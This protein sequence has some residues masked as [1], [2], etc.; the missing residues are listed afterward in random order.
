[1][2]GSPG[3][4]QPFD[5]PAHCRSRNRRSRQRAEPGHLRRPDRASAGSCHPEPRADFYSRAHPRPQD[6][7][8][9]IEVADSSIGYDQ[10]VK[11]LAYAMAGIPALV[12]ID[13]GASEVAVYRTPVDGTYRQHDALRSDDSLQV[14]GVAAAHIRVGDLFD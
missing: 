2:P 8:A 10:G 7:Y 13:L 4:R 5:Q 6:V 12:I 1:M 14:P 3:L 9:L 11:M